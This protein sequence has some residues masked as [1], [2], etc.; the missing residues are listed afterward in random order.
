MYSWM[1]GAITVLLTLATLCFV[2]IQGEPEAREVSSPSPAPG[3]Y[4]GPA[5]CPAM[6]PVPGPCPAQC[7]AMCP[8]PEPSHVPCSEATCHMEET[9]A[10]EWNGCMTPAPSPAPSREDCH[11]HLIVSGPAPAPQGE[12]DHLIVSG[13]A[14]APRSDKD[15]EYKWESNTV[16]SPAPSTFKNNKRAPAQKGDVIK[17][18]LK[19]KGKIT[20]QLKPKHNWSSNTVPSPAPSTENT[21]L[22]SYGPSPTPCPSPAPAAPE[23]CQHKVVTVQLKPRVNSNTVPSP[24]PSTENKKLEKEDL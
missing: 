22:S 5:P 8:A 15:S 10:K 12:F 16:P 7:P 6:C 19:P 20:V 14:P 1:V 17:I 21:P 9:S 13:P 3:P 23:H 18:Q 24:A 11:C 4:P 2:A